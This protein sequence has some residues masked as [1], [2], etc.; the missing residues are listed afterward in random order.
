MERLDE[1]HEKLVNEA[2]KRLLKFIDGDLPRSDSYS[3]INLCLNVL[4][5]GIILIANNFIDEDQE[6]LFIEKMSLLFRVNFD[7]N[8]RLKHDH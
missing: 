7:A 1:K 6:E 2:V 3:Y 8:R 4:T 5:G